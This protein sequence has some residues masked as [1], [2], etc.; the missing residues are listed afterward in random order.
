MA[1]VERALSFVFTKADGSAFANG[2]KTITIPPG[3]MASIRV[4]GA[5]MPG[6][7]GLQATVWGLTQDVMNQLSLLGVRVTLQPRNLVRV[8]AMNADGTNSSTAF[9]GGIRTCYPDFNGQPNPFLS[10][11]AYSGMDIAALPPISQGYNGQADLITV[12][13]SIC[14]TVGYTLENNGVS[15]V[16]LA[17]SYHWGSPRDALVAIRQAMA[18]RGVEIDI[19]TENGTTVAVW[20]IAKA[21]GGA[22]I[23][24]VSAGDANAPGTLIGYPTYTEFGIDFR[25]VYTPG[26]R[27]GGQVQV[28]SSLPSATGLWNLYGFAHALDAQI[29]SGKWETMAQANRSGYPQP[30]IVSN[31]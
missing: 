17:S 27:R 19:P 16:S 8:L 13:Q 2:A 3:N 12:L 21:R 9:Y 25:C 10:F 4:S 15:G 30:P 28:Q 23:P 7:G 31:I 14:D 1:F 29:P 11:Q 22:N 26:I 18:P 5:G 20:Y 24:L 6:M